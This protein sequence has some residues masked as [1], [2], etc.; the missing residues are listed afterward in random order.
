MATKKNKPTSF[1]LQAGPPYPHPPS[2]LT[3]R[4]QYLT[5]RIK[6]LSLAGRVFTKF[7][8]SSVKQA[9]YSPAWQRLL[10]REEY[11]LGV[12]LTPERGCPGGIKGIG[13]GRH[14]GRTLWALS[15]APLWSWGEARGL[16]TGMWGLRGRVEFQGD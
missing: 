2:G 8:R 7:F 9:E 12:G 4:Y 15:S 3:W 10:R 13:L 1:R 11:T 16:E 5:S 14:Q 6:F